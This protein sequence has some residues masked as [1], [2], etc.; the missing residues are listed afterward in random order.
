MNAKWSI[1]GPSALRAVCEG[2]LAP[3]KHPR[4]VF[5]ADELPRTAATGQIQRKQ[6][7]EEILAA[8]A[9]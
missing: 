9:G 4:R 3:H 7:V 2:K 6:L 5:Y 8:R 1:P